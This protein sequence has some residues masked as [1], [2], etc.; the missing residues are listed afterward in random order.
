MNSYY[1]EPYIPPLPFPSPLEADSH[2]L[3]AIGGNLSPE[4]VF[5]A[6][7][8]GIFP[9]FNDD[10]Q[11]ILWWSPD[12]RAIFD[13]SRVHISRSMRRFIRHSSWFIS[14]DEAFAAVMK[15]C[16]SPQRLGETRHE[17]WITPRMRSVYTTL[18]RQGRAHSCEVWENDQLIG[19]LYGVALENV[20]CAESMFS[21][22]PNASKFALI[23]LTQHLKS[24]GIHYIDSQFLTRHLASMGAYE[25]RRSAYLDLLSDNPDRHR[26]KWN[27][28]FDI[29]EVLQNH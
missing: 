20:F 22:R 6:H 16:A 5:A 1:L 29:R 14:L 8:Q 4:R 24:L 21:R 19:G 18:H 25:I 10:S 3:I 17:T 26:G 11:A 27:L 23:V 12:P 2:G 28:N 7:S 9:W 15:Q 13:T